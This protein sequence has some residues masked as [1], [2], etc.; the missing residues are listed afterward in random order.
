MKCACL[1]TVERI[2]HQSMPFMG[3]SLLVAFFVYS[4]CAILFRFS[5]CIFIYIYCV[6]F[7]HSMAIHRHTEKQTENKKGKKMERKTNNCIQNDSSMK[8]VGAIVGLIKR[9]KWQ[10]QRPKKNKRIHNINKSKVEHFGTTKWYTL[11][12]NMEMC[13]VY[14]AVAGV[15]VCVRSYGWQASVE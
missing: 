2:P 10:Q 12:W 14:A 5:V 11:I 15:C 4:V 7:I 1:A 3:F 9:M 8:T 13:A 6:Q